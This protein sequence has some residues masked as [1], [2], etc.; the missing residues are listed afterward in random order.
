MTGGGGG[1][2]G[3]VGGGGGGGGGGGWWGGGGGEVGGG[4]GGGG[5]GWGWGGGGG[6]W[7]G[8]GGGGGGGG[9]LHPTKPSDRRDRR[10]RN[11]YPKGC[12]T[13]TSGKGQGGTSTWRWGGSG[14][15]ACARARHRGTSRGSHGPAAAARASGNLVLTYVEKERGGLRTFAEE[16][17]ASAPIRMAQRDRS[18]KH[19]A[20]AMVSNQ[21]LRQESGVPTGRPARTGLLRARMGRLFGRGVSTLEWGAERPKL[22]AARRAR[23][24]SAASKWHARARGPTPTLRTARSSARCWPRCAKTRRTAGDGAFRRSRAPSPAA[25]P[26]QS[27]LAYSSKGEARASALSVPETGR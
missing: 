4:G 17:G 22:A 5:G 21:V 10:R 23:M 3:G 6:G 12:I 8:G 27:R 11:T 13:I 9:P 1:G 14:A 16:A 15:E 20:W 26:Q 18:K 2:V 19:A 25:R 24:W 7:W